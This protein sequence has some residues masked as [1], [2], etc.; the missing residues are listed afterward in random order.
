LD[1]GGAQPAGDLGEKSGGEVREILPWLKISAE[2]DPNRIETYMVTA[3]WLRK[4]MGKVDEAEQFLREGLRANPYNPAI[5]FELGRIYEEDRKDPNHARNLWELGVTRMDRQ[6][7]PKDEPDK[8]ILF[9]LTLYLAR[10]EEKQGNLQA[11]LQWLERVKSVSPNPS[12]IETQL[13]EL[14]QKAA[15]TK[16]SVPITPVKSGDS[17]R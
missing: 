12:E 8:F 16:T 2:L 9:Q 3:Y 1:E 15:T 13:I 14:R 7:E 6:V 4:R 17:S 11:A 10:L 5:L